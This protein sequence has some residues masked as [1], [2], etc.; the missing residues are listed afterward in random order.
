V[1]FTAA[2]RLLRACLPA[3]VEAPVRLRLGVGIGVGVD[4]GVDALGS[5]WISN[6]FMS[7]TH[8]GVRLG[9]LGCNWR[10]ANCAMALTFVHPP[11]IRARTHP[12][13]AAPTPIALAAGGSVAA[14]GRSHHHK[15]PIR[16][17]MHEVAPKIRGIKWLGVRWATLILC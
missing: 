15:C 11:P 13:E 3:G 10:S 12:F 2:A 5:A 4:V 9:L 1:P 14:G 7:T 17:Y 16:H 8:M 6:V